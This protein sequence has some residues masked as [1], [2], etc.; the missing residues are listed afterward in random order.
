MKIFSF[1]ANKCL[2][3]VKRCVIICSDNRKF[4]RKGDFMEPINETQKR[5]YEFLVERSQDGVPP[6]VREIGA[7]VA[8]FP[9]S[10]LLNPEE[11]R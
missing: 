5:I 4:V 7:A 2:L 10:S 6:S 9:S 1:F 11:S 8:D 3:F